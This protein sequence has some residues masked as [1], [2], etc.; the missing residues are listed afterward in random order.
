LQSRMRRG[1]WDGWI[2]SPGSGG[3]ARRWCARCG[4]VGREVKRLAALGCSLQSSQRRGRR[5]RGRGVGRQPL[6]LW[7]PVTRIRISDTIR[8][9]Y[10]VTRGYV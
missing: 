6:P 2:R 4:V 9:G 7:K 8:I 5:E 10:V 1:D 3:E